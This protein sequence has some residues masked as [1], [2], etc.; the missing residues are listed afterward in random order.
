MLENPIIQYCKPYVVYAH[1]NKINGKIYIGITCQKP[2][3]RWGINGYGYKT[4]YFGRAIEKYGWDNF[5]HFVIRENLTYREACLWEIVL[6]ASL[7]TRNKKYGYN[8]SPGGDLGGLGNKRTE[9]QK[10][11]IRGEKNIGSIPVIRINDEKIFSC[12]TE[13]AKDTG[14]PVSDVRACCLGLYNY[15]GYEKGTKTPINWMF[16]AEWEELSDIRKKIIKD[17]KIIQTNHKPVVYLEQLIVFNT[18]KSAYKYAGLKHNQHI[19]KC[20]NGKRNSAGEDPITGQ[21][22][23]W[24]Y[25]S[26]FIEMLKDN[27]LCLSDFNI[28]YHDGPFLMDTSYKKGVIPNVDKK[29]ANAI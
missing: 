26:D 1:R 14:L 22:M 13:A 17:S 27:G 28:T 5:D 29:N 19:I 9:E 3:V 7:K 6:I 2:N 24:M 4:Q 23:T 21:P 8:T 20:L 25:Y 10:A 12:I 11:K 16:L 15:S 18:V